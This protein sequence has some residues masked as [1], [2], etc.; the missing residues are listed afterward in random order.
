LK[1]LS[2][3]IKDK[4][5]GLMHDSPGHRPGNIKTKKEAFRILSNLEVIEK[6]I[7]VFA[8]THLWANLRS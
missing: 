7:Q 5:E 1:A 4:L 6:L 8:G 2:A 3:A